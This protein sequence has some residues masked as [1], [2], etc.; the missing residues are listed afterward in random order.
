MR[1]DN[2]QAKQLV[3]SGFDSLRNRFL[4]NEFSYRDLA[5]NVDI[6][7]QD[8]QFGRE[9]RN[10]EFDEN[11]ASADRKEKEEIKQEEEKVNQNILTDSGLN[12]YV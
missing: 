11:L 3:E 10:S 5:L 4:D 12:L 6:N 1:V 8:T 2:P 9:R 7:E